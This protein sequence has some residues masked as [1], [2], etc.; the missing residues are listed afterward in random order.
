M[1]KVLHLRTISGKGGGPEKTI[2]NSPRYLSDRF[3]VRVAYLRPEGD[4]Q[5]DMPER[6]R[7]LGVDL[8]DIP[9]RGPV[10]R[11]ALKQLAHV[12]REFKPDILHAHD[13]KTNLLAIYHRRSSHA[14]A[15]TTMHGYVTRSAKLQL[16]YAL[17]RWALRRM[18][19]VIAVSRDLERQARRM[20]VGESRCSFVANGIDVEQYVPKEDRLALRRSLE[21]PVDKPLI[22]AV[23]RLSA[24]KGFVYLIKALRLVVTEGIDAHLAIVGEGEQRAELAG[25]SSRLRLS[26]RVHLLGHR[27][28]LVDVYS[29]FDVF[30][31][32]SLR[33]G[34][35]NVLLEAMAMGLPVVATRTGSVT[36]V[37]EDGVNGLLVDPGDEES[38]AAA[39]ARLLSERID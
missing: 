24:E 2:L 36:D 20:G 27:S 35:P 17:D 32:S 11:R 14:A 13:Y 22:G 21:L 4:P 33:E 7:A 30:A 29:C 5:Y 6:A 16:Y 8:F 10:D 3:D 9:E 26:D 12:I 34:L 38:L 31:L 15:V 23:G 18:D 25:L 37:I 39:L 19:H 28:D 1:K